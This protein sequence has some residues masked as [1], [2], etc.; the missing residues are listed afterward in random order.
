MFLV[1]NMGSHLNCYIIYLPSLN[2]HIEN[3]H[4]RQTKPTNDLQDT[5][6]LFR[7]L[8]ASFLVC[9]PDGIR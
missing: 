4:P 6:V 5:V 2:Y 9:N 7:Y 1:F 8:S 3:H